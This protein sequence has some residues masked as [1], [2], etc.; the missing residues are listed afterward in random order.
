MLNP[1]PNVPPLK[2]AILESASP[3]ARSVL[4]P[5]HPRVQA[6]ARSLQ[7]I[8]PEAASAP[9]EKVLDAS[10]R[11][12]GESMRSLTWPWQP[13]IADPIPEPP[14]KLWQQAAHVPDVLTGFC[15]TEGQ[16]FIQ[17]NHPPFGEFW[18]TLIPNLPLD[19]LEGLYPASLFGGDERERLYVAYGDY[20][21]KCPVVHTAHMV[22][23]KG[24]RAYLYE[25]AGQDGTRGTS[26]HCSHGG[27]VRGSPQKPGL[28]RVSAEMKQRWEAFAAGRMGVEWPVFETPFG[29]DGT[30]DG[31][32]LVFGEGNDE[33][34]GGREE[35]T[36]VRVRGLSEREKRV[37]EFWWKYMELSQGMGEKGGC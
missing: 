32:I 24:G 29:E 12:F 14:L 11:V 21:Y 4:S 5:Q 20:A 7:S 22:R 36:A 31:E 27:V 1:L 9:L 13:V 17:P 6:Q 2:R 16:T 34:A 28:R 19:E 25:Y 30:G 3:T 33:A 15:R 8:L 26:A 23:S 10:I 18:A 35:G 37:C